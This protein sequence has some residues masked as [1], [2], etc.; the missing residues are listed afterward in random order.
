M[1]F[2]STLRARTDAP[3]TAAVSSRFVRELWAGSLPDPVLAVY[4]AQ[5]S[6]FVDTF[7]ALLGAAVATADDARVRI[8]LA[9]QLGLVANDEDGYFARAL[10]RLHTRGAGGLGDT[11]AASADPE[12]LP[13]TE[14]FLRLMDEARAS[15]SYALALTVLL[16]AEWLYLDWGSLDAPTPPDWLHADWIDLHRGAGF[17]RWVDLL[18]DETDRVA[19]AAGADTRRR[20]EEM[21]ERAVVLE[22][23]FFD[24]AYE[25][26]TD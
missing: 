5:D 26:S 18:R 20:M 24:A 6:L 9:Q 11:A 19:A 23:A 2:T 12:P 16:V 8:R 17:A 3:W 15:Q 14:G 22:A 10:T 13:P 4:L 21:F 7:V 25:V 1:S